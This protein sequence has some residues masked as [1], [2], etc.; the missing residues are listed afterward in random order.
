MVDI[1]HQGQIALSNS[2]PRL[3]LSREHLPVFPYWLGQRLC[4]EGCQGVWDVPHLH[5]PKW[6]LS[7][8]PIF[9]YAIPYTLLFS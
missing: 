4:P 2:A 8:L 1:P 5:G 3:F 7:Y 6:Y 9:Y